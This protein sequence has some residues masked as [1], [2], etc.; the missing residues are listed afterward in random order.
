MS[1]VT[2]EEAQNKLTEL[3]QG[4]KGRDRSPRLIPE[5]AL[6]CFQHVAPV[7]GL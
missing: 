5:R 6:V 1:T 4:L 2:T 7:W 3:V